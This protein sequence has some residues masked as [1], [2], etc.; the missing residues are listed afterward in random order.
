MIK[1]SAN[2]S[3]KVPLPN[4]EYSMVQCGGSLEIEVSDSDVDQPEHIK[5]KV[6]RLYHLLDE[7]ID[8]QIKLAVSGVP[9]QSS[10][11]TAPSNG[12]HQPPVNRVTTATQTSKRGAL[13]T[14][15]QVRAI[16]AIASRNGVQ[17][18]SVLSE[19]GVGKPE[20]LTVKAASELIDKLKRK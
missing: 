16:H 13:A 20:E 10:K 11:P 9:V 2:L 14:A 19:F 7:A 18:E 12:N 17:L 5:A 8:S 15:A 4:Q 3:K 1:V 6:A